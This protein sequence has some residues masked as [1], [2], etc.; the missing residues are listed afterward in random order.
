VCLSGGDITVW[1][2]GANIQRGI[3]LCQALNNGIFVPLFNGAYRYL[4]GIFIG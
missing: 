4:W 2:T 3:G 1:V